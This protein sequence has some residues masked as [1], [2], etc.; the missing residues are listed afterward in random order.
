M[1]PISKEILMQFELKFMKPSLNGLFIEFQEKQFWQLSAEAKDGFF[2]RYLTDNL[3]KD[4][5]AFI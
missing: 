5:F 2:S 3:F 4:N 1:Y